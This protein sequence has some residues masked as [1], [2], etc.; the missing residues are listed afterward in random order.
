MEGYFDN[1]PNYQLPSNPK[2]LEA[3]LSLL[4]GLGTLVGGRGWVYLAIEFGHV[5]LQTV[6]ERHGDDSGRVNG[7]VIDGRWQGRRES[8]TRDGLG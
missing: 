4:A 3:G 8:L 1:Y 5:S 2:P 6:L 7:C